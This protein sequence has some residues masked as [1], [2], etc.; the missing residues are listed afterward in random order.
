MLERSRAPI[1]ENCKVRGIGVAVIVKVS[2]FTFSCRS[3]SLTDTPNF[4]SSSMISKPRSLK[5]TSLPTIRWVPIKIF[6][7]PSFSSFKVA[8]ICVAVRARLI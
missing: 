7:S 5:R 6:T 4:C 8:L 1:K 3:F 2:T